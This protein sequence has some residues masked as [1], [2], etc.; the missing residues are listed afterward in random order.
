MVSETPV[1]KTIER[2]MMMRHY[3]EGIRYTHH[4]DHLAREV[5]PTGTLLNLLQAGGYILF[6]RHGEALVGTDQ[7]NL[8]F[9]D[10]NTQRNLTQKGRNQASTYRELIRGLNIPINIP[11][12]ASPFCRAFETAGLAFGYENVQVEPFLVEIYNLS[13][14]VTPTQFSNTLNQLITM[15]EVHP[16]TG[17]NQVIIAHSFPRGVGFGKLRDMETVIVRPRGRGMGF[18]VVD[19]LTLLGFSRL[20]S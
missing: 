8:N 13:F 18:E 15:L 9:Q 10:C 5:A 6:A 17:S 20:E 3:Y 1:T 11:V 4:S 14:N 16:P 19:Q 2:V 12:K 7:P